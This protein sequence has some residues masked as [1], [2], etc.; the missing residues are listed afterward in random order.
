MRFL[1][2][3][4]LHYTYKIMCSLIG[5]DWYQL[6]AGCLFPLW[7]IFDFRIK[8]IIKSNNLLEKKVKKWNN[9]PVQNA[10]N[11]VKTNVTCTTI[12]G[13]VFEHWARVVIITD[14]GI[15]FFLRFR[16]R[17]VLQCYF[18]RRTIITFT[19]HIFFLHK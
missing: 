8:I 15:L 7:Y 2:P 11:Y 10:N 4:A 5:F 18:M 6:T 17:H 12:I 16:W 9:G 13:A 1:F 14:W 3:P 19:P